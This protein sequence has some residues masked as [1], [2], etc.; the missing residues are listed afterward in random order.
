MD[1]S[2][3]GGPGKEPE[4]TRVEPLQEYFLV[5]SSFDYVNNSTRCSSPTESVPA[6]CESTSC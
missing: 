3:C 5:V 4:R 6:A 1:G 2:L